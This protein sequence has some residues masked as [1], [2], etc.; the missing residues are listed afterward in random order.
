MTTNLIKK[1]FFRLA[2]AL[3]CNKMRKTNMKNAA[4]ESVALAR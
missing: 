3:V 2:L 1:K 4:K